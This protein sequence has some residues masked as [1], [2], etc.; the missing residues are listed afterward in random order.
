MLR[1][2]DEIYHPVF[3]TKTGALKNKGLSTLEQGTAM[4]ARLGEFQ[5][6]VQMIKYGVP[7]N[8]R[9][10]PILAEAPFPDVLV[11]KAYSHDGDGL[12]LVLYPGKQAGDFTLKFDHLQPGAAYTFAGK[13]L[14]A[15]KSGELTATAHVDGRTAFKLARLLAN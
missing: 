1:Q 10:G 3:E 15:S 9:R 2:L 8:V 14:S 7:A 12:D 13:D 6:W 5:D 4:R 11:A